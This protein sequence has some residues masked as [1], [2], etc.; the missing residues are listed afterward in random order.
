MGTSAGYTPAAVPECPYVVTQTWASAEALRA[1]GALKENCVVTVPGP[2]IGTAGNT[3]AT[4]IT[5]QPVSATEFADE[6]LVNTAFELGAWQGTYDFAAQKLTKLADSSGNVAVD[7]DLTFDT[8]ATQVPWHLGAALGVGGW[9]DN[10]IEDTTLTAADT[11]VLANQFV[12]NTLRDTTM[13]FTGWVSGAITRTKVE[14]TGTHAITGAFASWTNSDITGGS[15]VNGRITLNNSHI[16]NSSQVINT[17]GLTSSATGLTNAT[18]K[19]ASVLTVLGAGNITVSGGSVVTNGSI[20]TTEA[21]V[22]AARSINVS[23]GSEIN[24][25][26]LRVDG[27]GTGGITL[28]TA[29]VY[30]RPSA[31]PTDSIL[32]SGTTTAGS[33]SYSRVDVDC[34]VVGA[35]PA[36]SWDGVQG[37]IIS[38][39][40]LRQARI[41][42]GVAAH[43]FQIANGSDILGGIITANGTTTGADARFSMTFS[44][45]TSMAIT[46]LPASSGSIS[47]NSCNLNNSLIEMTS[48]PKNLSLT[49]CLMNGINQASNYI[50]TS[51]TA[52]TSTGIAL[53]GT[54]I[55]ENG[56]LD[57]TETGAGS[58]IQVN[59]CVIKGGVLG[60]SFGRMLIDGTSD[61][62]SVSNCVVDD[63]IFTVT[64]AAAGSLT[65]PTS[66][67]DI[68][69]GCGGTFSVVNPS[70]AATRQFRHIRIQ[71]RAVFSALNTSGGPNF[72]VFGIELSDESQLNLLG[73][74][75]APVRDIDIMGRSV[76]NVNIGGSI[77]NHRQDQE[78]VLN[79]GAFS[80]FWTVF[81]LRNPLAVAVP[82]PFTCTAAN[83]GKLRSKAFDDWIGV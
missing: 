77:Q 37:A 14:G 69:V 29:R 59:R 67:Y 41:V 71:G 17:A 19:G 61:A 80:H 5:L 66:V 58:F 31:A 34:G 26:T 21:V 73:A 81:E 78:T 76:C 10:Y 45:L 70:A 33:I 56:R 13:D 49:D 4:F 1:G 40:I 55:R 16:E 51:N 63:G 6:A 47:F 39:S 48:G 72:D 62:F 22:P 64:N 3:S 44:R 46:Q 25:A 18:I 52:N 15:T 43:A 60:G 50:K 7:T 27:T 83:I 11:V 23:A 82:T 68:K 24:G 12:G 54:E 53:S 75:A 57:I 8:V 65:S 36:H 2:V 38:D 30:G 20:I 28:T 35:G 42:K 32:L 74:L 79:T 9:R